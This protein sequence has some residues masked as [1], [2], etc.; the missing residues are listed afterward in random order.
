VN[1]YKGYHVQEKDVPKGFSLEVSEKK[2]LHLVNAS[3]NSFLHEL[4]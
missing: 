2:K 3:G 1:Q 4:H